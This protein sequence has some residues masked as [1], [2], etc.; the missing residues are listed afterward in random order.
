MSTPGPG[1]GVIPW[2]QVPDGHRRRDYSYT[3]RAVRVH[4]PCGWRSTLARSVPDA[5][6]MW[7]AHIR[8]LAR[9]P[10]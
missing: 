6:M 3:Q 1:A 2:D 7:V 9:G 8:Q 4:C 5:R 10:R